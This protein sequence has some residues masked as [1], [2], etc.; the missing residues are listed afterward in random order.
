M[1]STSTLTKQ[2]KTMDNYLFI[3]GDLPMRNKKSREEKEK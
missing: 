1:Q 3:E 2:K